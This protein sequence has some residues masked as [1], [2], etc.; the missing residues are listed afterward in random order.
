MISAAAVLLSISATNAVASTAHLIGFGDSLI[1]SGNVQTF[2]QASGSSLDPTIYPDGQFTNGDTFASLLGMTP[3]LQ[4]G[5]NYAYGGAQ[6]VANDDAIPDILEQIRSFALSEIEFSEYSIATIWIGGNDFLRLPD[7][8]TAEQVGDA[9]QSVVSKIALSVQL[10]NQEF[11]IQNFLVMG[12]PDLGLLPR[13][14]GDPQSSA[15]ATAL[16]QIYNSSLQSVLAGLDA[17]LP[18]NVDFFDVDSFF[19]EVVTMVPQELIS[20]PCLADPAGCAANPE[21][22]LVYD[23]IHPSAWVHELLAEAVADQLGLA[24]V[25][26]P[27]TAPLLL[28]GLGGLGLWA[29]RRKSRA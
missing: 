22:Y 21:N 23:D 28:A 3:S 18:A 14:V 4:G 17:A 7:G 11:A 2:L 16:S 6:A 1:D 25:P 15:E 20:V 29:R 26:L 9:I 13:N 24:E 27:A 19:Q 5:T 10:L 8:A 12:L